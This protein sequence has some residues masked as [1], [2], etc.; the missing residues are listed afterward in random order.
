MT[1]NIYDDPNF[2]AGY[3]ALP[4]SQQGLDGAGEWPTLRAL[5][6][7]LDAADVVDLGC[8]FGWFCRWARTQGAA[9]VLGVDVSTN[10]LARA[11]ADTA[12]SAITY[13]QA[14]LEELRLPVAAFDLVYSS[15]TLHYL[16]D[17]PRLVG[18][19]ARALRPGGSFVASVEHPTYTAPTSPAWV[20]LGGHDVWPL[21]GYLL[22]GPRVTDWLAP[23]VVKQH[24][25]IATYVGALLEAG[26]QLT[27][28]VEWGP[29]DD[30][31]VAHP[32]W[33]RERDRSPFLLLA[34]SCRTQ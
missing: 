34:A 30:D 10:M 6:P 5:V 7:P 21:D 1:Q 27:A 9:S 20:T 18:E 12:D 25:T 26:M 23:G 15:L 3:S 2:F 33:T 17:L 29:S 13:R 32:D 31:L 19:I 4:R 14:D 11:A 24:R 8:G 16:R 28:L 22:E